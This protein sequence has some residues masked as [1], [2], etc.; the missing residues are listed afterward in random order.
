MSENLPQ[1]IMNRA[2]LDGLP[3]VEVGA[4]YVL[5][6]FADGDEVSAAVVLAKAFE[7]PNWTPE[8]YRAELIDHPATWRTWVILADSEVVATCTARRQDDAPT[9][10]YVHYVGC[11]PNHAGH[12]LGRLVTLQVL[13][14]FVERGCTS[15]ILTTDDFR[16]P[17]IKGYLRLGFTPTLA[18]PSHPARWAKLR[19]VLGE[20]LFAG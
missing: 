3:A 15:A 12:G 6:P 17:A 14:E 1:L 10:G 8:R 16:V 5:R 13:H 4:P 19:A 2:D 18:H 7:D 9:E 11:H 20:E